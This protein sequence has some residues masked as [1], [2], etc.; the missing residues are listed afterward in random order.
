MAAAASVTA[1][2]ATGRFSRLFFV[3]HISNNTANSNYQNASY[4]NS[5]HKNPPEEL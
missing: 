2:A 5:P 1:A 4:K 3:N